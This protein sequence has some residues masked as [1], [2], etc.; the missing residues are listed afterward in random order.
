[1]NNIPARL[2]AFRT[3]MATHGLAAYLLPS[4]DPHQ[5][6]YVAPRWQTRPWLSGF[7]GSA[8]TLVV[9]P[10]DADIW[11]DSRYFIQAESELAGTGVKLQRQNVPHAPEHIAWLATNLPAGSQL[12]IDGRVVSLAQTRQLQRKLQPQGI[13]IVAEYD[14]AEECWPD[15]PARPRSTVFAFSATYAGESREQKLGRIQAWL[16][17]QQASAVLLVALDDIA[18]TLNIRAA[19]VA[20]NPVCISYLLVGQD[21]AQWFVDADRLPAAL[22]TEMAAAHVTVA[23]YEE[24]EAALRQFP[25]ADLLAIDPT[26][27]SYRFFGLLA[28][29]QLLETGS[30]VVAMKAVKNNTEIDH[31]RQAMRKDGVALL[32]LFRWLEAN[33]ARQQPVTEVTVAQ[34]LA[35][36]RSQQP[37]YFGESFP[38][39]VGYQANGAIVHYHAE[40]ETCATLQPTGMLLLDSGGQYLD[41]TTDITRTVAL[42]P[43]SADQRE[44]FTLVLK[45]MIALT[46]ARFPTGTGGAQ[47]DTLAR[48]FLWQKGLNYGHGTGHGVGFFLNV[49]E[50]PQ[51]FATS[52]VTSRGSTAFVP[53]MVTSNEPGFYRTGHYGIRTENLMLCVTDQATNYGNFLRF[54]TLTLFPIDRRLMQLELLTQSE[55][56]W[57]NAYHQL[58]LDNLL[59]L[60]QDTAERAWLQEQCAP[61]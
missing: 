54:E 40:P 3:A 30:P 28:D 41:G 31:L 60:L 39:I 26:T 33:L 61:L 49:H 16:K 15:R 50:G 32:R 4:S 46:E 44:H 27:L 11:T 6:E 1:M 47:L 55:V 45:G 38:A 21:H 59:P 13:K 42:G 36:Y 43:T 37:D 20:F 24:V 29:K 17:T 53:G 2:M 5:S 12:G 23:A 10:E 19:D 9:T 18:W 51:G 22:Q 48:Q 58:V 35:Q 25:S 56:D 7:T 14:L 52:A 34:Q 8:G 57:L